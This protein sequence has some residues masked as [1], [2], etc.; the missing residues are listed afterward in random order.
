MADFLCIEDEQLAQ[1]FYLLG[2]FDNFIGADHANIV[3]HAVIV[4]G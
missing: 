3:H 2:Y 4:M 1:G